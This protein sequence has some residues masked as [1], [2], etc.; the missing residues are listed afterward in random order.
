[1]MIQFTLLYFTH[2]KAYFQHGCSKTYSRLKK[3][4]L[5]S[6]ISSYMHYI[7]STSVQIGLLQFSFGIYSYHTSQKHQHALQCKHVK[8]YCNTVA[9]KNNTIQLTSY[10]LGGQ[11][12]KW[13]SIQTSLI[14][15][16]VLT[17]MKATLFINFDI[18]TP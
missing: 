7:L 12:M 11:N 3:K 18:N 4:G 2:F 16:V 6:P 8:N 9:I 5:H 17:L 15:V 1:M 14:T 10:D 13:F